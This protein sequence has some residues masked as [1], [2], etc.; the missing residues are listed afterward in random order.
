M[1]PPFKRRFGYKHKNVSITIEVRTM[2]T[3]KKVFAVIMCVVLTLTTAPL[4]GLVGLDLPSLFD[5]K[6]E[7]ATYSGTCGDKL[8][9]SLNTFTGVLNI[10]GTGAM[11]NWSYPGKVP[12]YSYCSSIKAVNIASGVTSIG[13]EAF[14]GCTSLTSVTI[15]DSVTS[16]GYSAFYGCS[17]L[18]SVTIPDSVGNLGNSAFNGCT[19][20]VSITIGNSVTSIGYRVFYGCSSLASVTIPD[21]VTSI[22]N[23]AFVKCTSLTDVYYGSTE[24]DWNKITIGS[25]NDSLTSATIYFNHP[26]HAAGEWETVTEPS[27]TDEGQRVKKCTICQKILETESIPKLTEHNYKEEITTPATCTTAGVKTFTCVCGDSYTETIKATGHSLKQI[28]VEATCLE[29]GKSCY[30]CQK[31]FIEYGVTVIPSRGHTVGEWETTVEPGC[32][33]EGTKVKKCTVCGEILETEAIPSNGHS[34][35][36]K[37]ITAPTCSAEG[38]AEYTCACGD[39]YSVK[40]PV[41]DHDLERYFTAPSSTEPGFDYYICKF[42][43]NM[44]GDMEFLP[45]TGF[46]P[47]NGMVVDYADGIVYGLNAGINSLDGYTDFIFDGYEWNYDE[48]QYG[49]GTGTVATL[50]NGDEIIAEYTVVIFGDIDGNGWYDA[51]DAFIVNMIANGLLPQENLPDY[52]RAAA[53]CNHDGEI[54]ELDFEILNNAS[55]L[56][57]NIDQSA[58]KAELATNSVYIEYMSLIDQSAGLETEEETPSPETNAPEAEINIE[59]FFAMIFDILKQILKFVLSLATK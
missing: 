20:L 15:P 13:Y 21:S 19:N 56:I 14:S 49:F 33:T 51:N 38:L 25:N 39:S 12:W 26:D 4:S 57:E 32:E 37:I 3:F 2:K 31:C 42:C 54:N 1:P 18:A 43:G 36:E 41:V 6:A 46:E 40:L 9:W 16:I 10:T 17:S 28:K 23:Y 45:P 8:T 59:S 24:G 47:T 30:Q 5:F 11:T 58:T 44:I 29:N 50:K 34:H 48:G 55:L 27:C 7:A 52:M 35:E 53:D 22:G